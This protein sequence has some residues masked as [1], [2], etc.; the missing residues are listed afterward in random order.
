MRDVARL[1]QSPF[2]E[3]SLTQP[4]TSLNMACRR[5]IK[6][7]DIPLIPALLVLV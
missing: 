4:Q 5:A 3:H 2:I 1:Q 6:G 7:E